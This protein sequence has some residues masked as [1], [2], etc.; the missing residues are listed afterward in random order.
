MSDPQHGTDLRGRG[1]ERASLDRLLDDVR[2]GQSRVLVLRGEAGIGKTALL[3]YLAANASGC[4]VARAAGVE[5]E[6]E[7]AFAG[8]HQLCAPLL[9][10]LA[11]LPDPQRDALGTAFGL[12]AGAATDR[13]LVGLAVL[14]LLSEVAEERPLVCLVDDAQWLDR[15]SAQVLGF[16]ARRLLA[17]PVAMVF[18]LRAP[19]EDVEL[20]ALPVM[21]VAGLSDVDARALLDSVTPGRL[22]ERVR[23]RIVAESSG[24]PLALLEL[25]NGLTAAE[26]AGGFGRPDARPLANLIEQSFLR[27]VRALPVE[28]QRLLLTAAAEPVGDVTLLWRAAEVL[29]IAAAAAAPAAA[30]RL[31][32]LGARVRF[33]HP[34]A[35]SAAYRAAAVEERQAVHRALAEVTD[36][37]ADPDRRAW[38]RAQAA[39][40][41]DETVADELERSA[42]RAQ[43]RGGM[44][45]AAAF[46]ERA[47]DLTPD[48]ARRG[49]RALAAAQAK[50]EAG[51]ANAAYGLLAAA[52][53]GPLNELQRAR[54]ARMRAHIVFAQS[55]GRDAPALLLDAAKRLEALQAGLARE[56]YVEALGAEIFVGRLGARHGVRIAEAARGAPP[57][58]EPPRPTD[59][60]LDGLAM[61]F[62]VGYA[63]GVQPLKRALHLFREQARC[64]MDGMVRWLWTACP[65]APEPLAAD[66]WDDHAWHELATQAVRLARDA[67]ALATLPI[68][69]SYRAGVHV[70]AGEFAAASALIQEADSI[71]E[72]TGHAP[73]RYTS[74]ALAAWRGEEA[75]AR[76]LIQAAVKEANARGEGRALGLAGYA[77]AVL[78]NGLGRY[79]AALDAA[80]EA[81]EYDDLGFF[82][83]CLVELIE[84]AVRSG[85]T[86]VAAA[87]LGH[88]EE[89]APAAATDWALGSLARGRAL[90]E[91]GPA[92]EALYREALDR[93][94]ACRMVVHLARAHLVYGEWLRRQNRR[95]DARKQLRI[96]HE[97]LD[98]IGAEAFAERARGELLATGETVRKRTADSRDALT[99]QE[100]LV[101]RLAAQGR[102]NPEIGA[103]LFI[104]SRTAEYH[105][106]KVFTKLGISS[107][108]SLRDALGDT[109][110]TASLI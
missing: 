56:A 16:V 62:T 45:A 29:G 53:M 59:L 100:A 76:G 9:S 54:V 11:H 65:V 80:R 105:L 38:H 90:L 60:L 37:R 89:R 1:S 32:E 19:N 96:A 44:A 93:L 108:R 6:V 28:T 94:G 20:R 57:P 46:L 36:P 95:V 18:A 8:L 84:A 64:G 82:G 78:Y 101:A 86:D 68:A 52:D 26:L 69:L 61:R 3:E 91:D 15:A 98:Q 48:P 33:R 49:V 58:S 4:R 83:W 43:T 103:Q 81:C 31:V 34:L 97:M 42:G 88:L 22:D 27:R 47:T 67:G 41:P 24:N 72:A 17:E 74:L 39:L 77:S 14:T 21:V 10:H 107:R 106:R 104:S 85:A 75:H 79:R 35:R 87:A 23:D 2:G 63:A 102:T 66:L 70:H 40:G 7:L 25:P 71:T 92:A 5:S 99:A 12:T 13:F 109:T 73:L 50:F 110:H 55:R 51:A 30:E